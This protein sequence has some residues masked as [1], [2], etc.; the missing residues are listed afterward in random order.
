MPELCAVGGEVVGQPSAAPMI[1]I[2]SGSDSLS[3]AL[4]PLS[5]NTSG[6][7][8]GPVTSIQSLA[9]QKN[10]VSVGESGVLGGS[11]PQ[12]NPS[13]LNLIPPNVTRP[14]S[15]DSLAFL[16][17]NTFTPWLLYLVHFT[18]LSAPTASLQLA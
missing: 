13:W 9:G 2:S 16:T 17:V 4:A 6:R 1:S 3:N 14:S 7:A 10:V 15:N 8:L 5:A 18:I 11:S 12:S